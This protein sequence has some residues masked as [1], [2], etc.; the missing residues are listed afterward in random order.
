MSDEVTIQDVLDFWFE[1]I[2]EESW[3]KKDDAFDNLL[4]ERFGKTVE[5]AVAGKLDDW[6]E[7]AEGLLALVILL[8]QMTRNIYR[9]TPEA[10]SG[11]DKAL[12]L[13]LKGQERGYLESFEIMH[14]R[15]FLLMPMMHSEDIAI[16][17]ASLPLF[18]KY[19]GEL[20]HEYAVKHR[21]IVARFGH[22]P[23]RSPILGRPLS[24]EEEEFLKGPDS[25][26]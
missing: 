3:F 16:Q 17:E 4:R 6:A 26:F 25:S 12:A 9:D 5:M 10:F 15:H 14:H 19:S 24:A 18:K 21:D 23:H 22:F 7:S 11:D 2:S 1:E 20:T 13:S 8:D